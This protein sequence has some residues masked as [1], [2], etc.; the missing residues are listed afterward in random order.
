VVDAPKFSLRDDWYLI[1]W[2]PILFVTV[3]YYELQPVGNETCPYL[4]L[5]GHCSK[6]PPTGLYGE[7]LRMLDTWGL[8]QL[9]INIFSGSGNPEETAILLLLKGTPAALVSLSALI[10]LRLIRDVV[11]D[12]LPPKEELLNK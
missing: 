1:V 5:A 8:R 10:L 4:T 6:T 12:Y 7:F 11:R 9:L 2:L 3:I